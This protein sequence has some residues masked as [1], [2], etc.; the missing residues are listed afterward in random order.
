L[1]A[2]NRILDITVSAWRAQGGTMVIPDRGRIYDEGDV[3][4]YRDMMTIVRD[5]VQDAIRKG[6][7]LEQV[8]AA[9][10]ARDYDGRYGA[11]GGPASADAFIATVYRSLSAAAAAAR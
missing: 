8:Q 7:T 10:L 3:A 6:L 9:R 4:E 1:A 5:R 11:D 2:L